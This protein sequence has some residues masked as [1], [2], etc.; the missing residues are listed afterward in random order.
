MGP[1][2]L[3]A[4]PIGRIANSRLFQLAVVVL[5]ILLLDHYSYD[6]PVLRPIAD[7]L[8]ALVNATVQLCAEY[9]RIGI[10]TDPVLQVGVMI[11]YVYVVCLLIYSLL[12]VFV[13]WLVDLAGWSN[14]LWLRSAIA[15]E[16]GIAAYRAWLPLERIRPADCPQAQWEEEFAWPANNE[17]PYPP[18]PRRVLHG[19]V[20]YIAV[21]GGAAVLLQYFTPFP[22]LTWLR[23]L[24]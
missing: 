8:K 13:R 6:Y 20:A 21:L 3:L 10:L 4:A 2:R 16:R 11:A 5:I 18:L 1:I 14:F 9:F 7:G 17:P 12:R 22:V 24:L 19:A 15:R 23:G